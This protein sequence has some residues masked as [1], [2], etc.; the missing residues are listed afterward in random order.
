MRPFGFAVD[1]ADEAFAG[2]PITFRA[3]DARGRVEWDFGD[4]NS[5][6]GFE[7]QHTYQAGGSFRITA[8]SGSEVVT[9]GLGV[10]ER[11]V[12]SGM[13]GPTTASPPSTHM[14]V[15][16]PDAVSM[17]LLVTF[18]A[19]APASEV[20]VD[21]L[22]DGTLHAS[23]SSADSPLEWVGWSVPQGDYE[24]KVG[25]KSGVGSAGY[26]LEWVVRYW[27]GTGLRPVQVPS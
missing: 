24:A 25:L 18:D 8:S 26:D 10:G 27:D 5:G 17:T 9:G 22:R 23:P 12:A 13:V 15:V 2:E 16:G 1:S 19:S 21:V 11:V 3:H 7:V 20:I 6:S 14:L 4:G